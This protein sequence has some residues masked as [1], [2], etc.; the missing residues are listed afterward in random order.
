MKSKLSVVIIARNEQANIGECIASVRDIADEIIVVD[1]FSE[2]STASIATAHGA[3]VYSRAMN[4]NWGEQQTFG[5]QQA[6]REWLLL[7]DCDE[8]V[9]EELAMEISDKVNKGKLVAYQMPRKNYFIGKWV[10]YGGWYPDYNVR[11]LPRS[12]SCVAGKVHPVIQHKYKLAR[13]KNPLIHFNY[14]SWEQYLAKQNRYSS[15]AAE[16]NLDAGKRAQIVRD[17]VLRPIFAFVKKYV[18]QLGLLDGWLGWALANNY[19][20]YTL[21]KYVK[22]YQRQME[23]DQIQQY[24]E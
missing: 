14:N 5:I 1:D 23:V 24:R 22:L 16:K 17:F 10:R 8:R 20:N 9:T 19:A 4:G 6:S 11:L 3:A 15:L 7:L 2:D 12:G 13:L 21:N 18:F